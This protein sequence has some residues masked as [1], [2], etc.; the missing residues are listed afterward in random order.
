MKL[1]ILDRDGVINFDSPTSSSRRRSGKRF[2]A[3]RKPSPAE[4]GRLS[5][6]GGHQPVGSRAR[7]F[8]MDTLNAIHDKMHKTVR[9]P[10]GASTRFSFARTGRLEL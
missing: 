9:R 2:P 8:D 4:S 6:G 7:L 3:A 5:R 10:A 1:V